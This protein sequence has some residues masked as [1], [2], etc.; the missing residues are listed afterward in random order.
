VR[1]HPAD[2]LGWFFRYYRVLKEEEKVKKYV[3]FRA[4]PSLYAQL[5]NAA[6]ATGVTRSTIIREALSGA[7]MKKKY[8][9]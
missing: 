9:T 5:T 6:K 8:R 3:H 7:L 2:Y 4:D 1:G